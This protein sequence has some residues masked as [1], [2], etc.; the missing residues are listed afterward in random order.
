MEEFVHIASSSEKPSLERMEKFLRHHGV[1]CRLEQHPKG[2]DKWNLTVG[3]AHL[4]EAQK[5]LEEI[6]Y[7]NF[8]SGR[9]EDVVEINFDGTE[10]TEVST[11]L[12]K[13]RK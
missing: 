1:D 11:W 7:R 2:L 8:D 4:D 9:V 10:R 12:R 6:A 13:A 5:V 3:R